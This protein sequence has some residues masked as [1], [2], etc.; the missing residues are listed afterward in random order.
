MA[1]K[2]RLYV[3]CRACDGTGFLNWGDSPSHPGLRVCP[4]CLDE[5]PPLGAK[6]FDGVRHVYLGRFEEV[7]EE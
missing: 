2:L 3:P 4:E 5:T 7:V 6:V 1:D